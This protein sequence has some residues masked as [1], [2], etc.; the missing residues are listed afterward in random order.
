VQIADNGPGIPEENLDKIW[1]SFY[2]TKG[3]KHAGLGLSAARRIIK[4]LEGELKAANRPEG[5]AIFEF[6]LPYREEKESAG[7][8]PSGLQILLIDDEDAWQREIAD[9]LEKAG[10]HITRVLSVPE[11]LT[12]FDV[13]LVDDVLA[14]A[15]NVQILKA[16]RASGAADQT[17][18][19]ASRLNAERATEIV[20]FGVQ[21]VRVK[22]YTVAGLVELFSALEDTA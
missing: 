21:D 22:P 3:A 2:T 7:A 4:Q 15:N 20:R 12:P 16:L 13:I 14:G 1:A 18:V 9:L 17:L 5:G 19:V 6:L 10:N 11:D 8:L